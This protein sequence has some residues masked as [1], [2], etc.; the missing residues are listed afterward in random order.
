[1]KKKIALIITMLSVT[2]IALMLLWVMWGTDVVTEI[3]NPTCQWHHVYACSGPPTY[4]RCIGWDPTP[5]VGVYY[6]TEI[7]KSVLNT[8]PDSYTRRVSPSQFADRTHW[9]RDDFFVCD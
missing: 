2:C 8:V 6:D 7:S 9:T 5:Q 4:V 1:M 3:N